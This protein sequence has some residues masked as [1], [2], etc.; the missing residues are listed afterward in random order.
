MNPG[1]HATLN[2]ATLGPAAQR[3][4]D[5]RA[6][7]EAALRFAKDPFAQ[8]EHGRFKLRRDDLKKPTESHLQKTISASLP[9]IRVEQLLMEVDQ[10]TGFTRSFVPLHLSLVSNAILYWNTVKIGETVGRL[11][12]EGESIDDEEISHV[13]LLPFRHVMP[14]G[15]YFIEDQI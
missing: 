3:S 9:L 5:R 10:A 4:V 15:T 2:P 14:T 11:R 7:S 13:S 8:I 12:A 1:T 6:Y